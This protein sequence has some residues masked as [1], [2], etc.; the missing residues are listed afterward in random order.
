MTDLR[1]ID[2]GG[3]ARTPGRKGKLPLLTW[4][5]IDRLRLDD[6]YQRGLGKSNWRNIEVIA[7]DFDWARFTPILAA[8]LDDGLFAIIDGQHRTHAAA[9]RGFDAV[10]AMVV[11]MTHAEQARAFAWVNGQVTAITVYHVYKAALVA[12]EPWALDAREIV[13]Q[14]GCKLLTYPVSTYNRRPREIDAIGLVRDHVNAGRGDLLAAAF[15]ALS[16]SPAGD[17]SDAWR[18]TI[19]NGL[20]AAMVA[21]GDW[22]EIDLPAFFEANDIVSI[23]DKVDTMRKSREGLAK[24]PP[25]KVFRQTLVA[26]F[27]AQV[28]ARA[29]RARAAE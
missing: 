1:P 22:R 27:R 18:G 12:R 21:F 19:L 13:E 23:R 14:A 20:L 15:G 9:L 4:L 6:S 28:K 17:N 16:A 11:P 5:A 29:A 8:P 7:A 24:E 10:P 2:L 25:A 26:L 3:R